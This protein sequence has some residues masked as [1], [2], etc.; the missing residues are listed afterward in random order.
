MRKVGSF[1]SENVIF[2]LEVHCT[3]SDVMIYGIMLM[4]L[5]PIHFTL[6]F[7]GQTSRIDSI[8]VWWLHC[9]TC[10]VYSSTASTLLSAFVHAHNLN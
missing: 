5:G 6:D 2:P 9:F 8:L 3:L 10:N 7:P 1:K 4:H